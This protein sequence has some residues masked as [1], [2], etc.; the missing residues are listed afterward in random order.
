MLVEAD[1][2]GI[3][4]VGGAEEGFGKGDAEECGCSVGGGLKGEQGG[5]VLL[6]DE[7]D[8]DGVGL[9]DGE[10]VAVVAIASFRQK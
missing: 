9:A 1:G 2:V 6:E 3:L 10:G 5:E 4:N 7:R 8:G